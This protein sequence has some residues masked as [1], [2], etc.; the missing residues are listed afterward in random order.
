MALMRPRSWALEEL[1]IKFLVTHLWTID[2][3]I[4]QQG[5]EAPLED[6]SD[7]LVTSSHELPTEPNLADAGITTVVWAV[8]YRP[9]LEW[10]AR[11][12]L[13]L[14]GTDD[15]V[16]N[17]VLKTVLGP[18]EPEILALDERRL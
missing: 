3:Q 7:D 11:R 6:W 10:A 4:I 12:S 9:E 8:G 14:T 5:L 17:Q 2:D 15:W 13:I 1:V 18:I 16:R